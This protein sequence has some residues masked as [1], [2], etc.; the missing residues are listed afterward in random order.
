MALHANHKGLECSYEKLVDSYA[1]LEI[2][3]E[4]VLSLIELMQPLSHTCTCSQVEIDL[5]ST[6]DCLS[7]ESQCSIEHVIVESYDDLIVKKMI[8]SSKRLKSFKETC[9]C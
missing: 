1:T 4:V 3:H 7:Q 5:S 2:A 8:N 9:M 6:N